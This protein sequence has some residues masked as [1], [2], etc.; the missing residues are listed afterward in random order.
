MDEREFEKVFWVIQ[1]QLMRYALTQLD[2]HA[3]EDAVSSTLLTLWRKQ[4][5]VPAD[6]VEDQQLRSLAYKVLN[7]VIKN[8]YRSRRRRQALADRVGAFERHPKEGA[9]ASDQIVGQNAVTHW[10]SQLSLDDQQIVLLFNAGFGTEEIAQILGCSI[11]AAAKRRT[12]ARVRLR[13]IV[14]K[15]RGTK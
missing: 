13:A 11:A 7:G 15:E 14:N 10:L 4:L 8:E 12:R 9:D 6:D 2:A 1:P 3:A 5:S